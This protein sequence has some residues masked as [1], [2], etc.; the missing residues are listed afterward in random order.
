MTDSNDLHSSVPQVGRVEWIGLAAGRRAPI[1][2][3]ESVAV[4]VGRGLAGDH[5]AT[6]GQ[7]SMRQVTFI[8][9]EHLPAIAGL[10]GHETVDPMLLRRNIV[11]SGI[12]L[13]SL[14]KRRFAIGD[15]VFE[16]TGP[17]AP[18]SLM[19]RNL[20]PGGYQAM[21]G[22]GGITTTVRQGGT[23]NLGDDVQVIGSS[24]ADND[25]SPDAT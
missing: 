9:A 14:K 18:C 8:Q 19:E 24:D 7:A 4:E 20:G 13:L 21:R 5:H 6:S 22:H 2:V 1:E 16:G 17:C 15:A 23:I 12:N 3:V 11:V 25:D 10:C